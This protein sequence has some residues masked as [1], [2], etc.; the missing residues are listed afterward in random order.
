MFQ[1]AL[2]PLQVFSKDQPAQPKT[3]AVP[4]RQPSGDIPSSISSGTGGTYEESASGTKR[5]GDLGRYIYKT[6]TPQAKA[7]DGVGDFSYASEHPDFGGSF[8]RSYNSWHNVNRAIDIGGFWPEDQK[9]ILAKILEFN[10]QTGA[11]PVELLYGKPGTPQSGTH[12]DHVHVA[13]EGGGYV[14]GKYDMNRIK[15]YASYEAGNSDPIVIPLPLPQQTPAPQ[16]YGDN[17][18]ITSVISGG[19]R[20]NPFEFLDF[21]G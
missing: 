13:Y 18:Q 10:Q 4:S 5:A 11:T 12:K 7:A 1:R 19:E 3:P 9:K 8:K 6:L 15:T 2:D 14:D 17:Q 20:S 16:T 21:Q